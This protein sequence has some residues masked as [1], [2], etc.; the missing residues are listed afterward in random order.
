M[1]RY[2]NIPSDPESDKVTTATHTHMHRHMHINTACVTA[3]L[4]WQ[5]GMADYK[6]LIQSI[7]VPFVPAEI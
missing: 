4:V 7:S 3:A 1:H 2:A 6:L 5:Q